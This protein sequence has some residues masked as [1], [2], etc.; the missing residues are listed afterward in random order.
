MY[1]DGSETA[2]KLSKLDF[3]SG[4]QKRVKGTIPASPTHFSISISIFAVDIFASENMTSD[5][6]GGLSLSLWSA[7]TYQQMERG[8]SI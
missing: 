4:V 5:Y 7:H 8:K 1:C 2:R 3:S 6:C